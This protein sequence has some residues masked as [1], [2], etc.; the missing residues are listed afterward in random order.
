[1]ETAVKGLVCAF[2]PK[3]GFGVL[4]LEDGREITFDVTAC[5][6]EP[7][8]GQAVRRPARPRAD[9]R[10]SGRPGRAR[11]RAELHS[12]P[13]SLSRGRAAAAE[14]GPRSRARPMGNRRDRAGR[15]RTA[16]LP[17][18]LPLVLSAYYRHEHFGARRRSSDQY[19]A[20]FEG[21]EVGTFER[22]L[23]ELLGGGAVTFEAFEVLMSSIDDVSMPSTR[24][25]GP[26]ATPD[27]SSSRGRKRRPRL[28]LHGALASHAPVGQRRAARALGAAPPHAERAAP[29]QRLSAPASLSSARRGSRFRREPAGQWLGRR[30]SGRERCLYVA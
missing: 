18:H 27:A 22:E 8:E 10:G 3:N 24:S 15:G 20:W 4:E 17:E 2:K 28:L 12:S 1:M 13:S 29:A 30:R 6:E 9:R 26:K 21:R 14:R 16:E 11:E 25:C 7:L 19:V 5:V 23:A